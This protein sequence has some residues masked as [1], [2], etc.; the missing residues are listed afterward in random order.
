MFIDEAVSFAS[1]AKSAATSDQKTIKEAS[2][3]D[4]NFLLHIPLALK[5]EVGRKTMFIKDLL[6][7]DLNAIVELNKVVGSPLN[8]LINDKL[9]AKGE[10]VI[11]TEKFGLRIVEII[12]KN[13]RLRHIQDM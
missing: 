10:V 2:N 11:Q 13:A 6:N 5:V 3:V 7:I 9:V 12:D 1:P 8:V 4:I